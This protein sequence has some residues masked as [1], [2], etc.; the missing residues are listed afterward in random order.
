[1]KSIDEMR[2]VPAP[3]G[4]SPRGPLLLREEGEFSA[5]FR[6][7]ASRVLARRNRRD[8]AAAKQIPVLDP[9]STNLVKVVL[10]RQGLQFAICAGEILDGGAR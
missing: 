3:G 6:L 8:L 5:E 1:M 10:R 4:A 7:K 9:R 2:R